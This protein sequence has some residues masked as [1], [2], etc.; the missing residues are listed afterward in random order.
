MGTQKIQL[1]KK[2]TKRK[3]SF[4]E[5]KNLP[6]G[7]WT[8]IKKHK[9]TWYSNNKNCISVIC[10]NNKRKANLI[11]TNYHGCERNSNRR[12]HSG[13]KQDVEIPNTINHY[14]NKKVGVD[15]GNQGLEKKVLFCRQKQ[16]FWLE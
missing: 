10:Y 2:E 9:Y 13:K 11:F 3:M 14:T 4:I 5:Y 1:K 8:G 6:N 12:T 16:M 7:R 15:V